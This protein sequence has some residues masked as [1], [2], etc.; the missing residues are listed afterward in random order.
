MAVNH[1]DWVG[2]VP[3]VAKVIKLPTE[4]TEDSNVDIALLDLERTPKKPIWKQG[5][6]FP[7][8]FANTTAN[9]KE[10]LLYDSELNPRGKTLRK[11]TREEL[12]Q[13]YNELREGQWKTALQNS[14]RKRF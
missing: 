8:K 6:N 4:L 3:Q 1:P 11:R 13:I 5:F 2:T 14:K 9:I 12:E 7:S 10:I